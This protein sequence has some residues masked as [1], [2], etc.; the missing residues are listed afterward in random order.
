MPRQFLKEQK[1]PVQGAG[2]NGFELRLEVGL[3]VLTSDFYCRLNLDRAS[4]LCIKFC[5]FYMR[6]RCRYCACSGTGRYRVSVNNNM[7]DEDPSSTW[8]SKG[9]H[10]LVWTSPHFICS[11]NNGE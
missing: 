11:G 10:H 8:G 4:F 3:A 1:D 5:S 7:L 2:K 6:Y 9:I